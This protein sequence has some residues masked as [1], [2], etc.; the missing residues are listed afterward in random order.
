MKKISNFLRLVFDWFW[1]KEI[2]GESNK[3][4][5]ENENASFEIPNI[6]NPKVISY[7]TNKVLVSSKMPGSEEINLDLP[8]GIATLKKRELVLCSCGRLTNAPYGKCS[9]CQSFI[10]SAESFFNCKKCGRGLC[11]KCVRRYSDIFTLVPLCESCFG[12]AKLFGLE[13]G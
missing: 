3:K 9:E 2:P 4:N 5:P 10:F 6:D 13:E 12:V 1:P 11:I 8:S 7:E